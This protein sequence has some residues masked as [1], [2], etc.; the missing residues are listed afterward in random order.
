MHAGHNIGVVIP[1]R[2]EVKFINRVLTTLPTWVDRAVVVDDGS[3]DGTAEVARQVVGQAAIDIIRLEGE[4]VGSAINAGHQH[5]LS[6]W[7]EPF[8]SVVMAGDGQ[9]NPNDLEAVVDPVTRNVVDHSK[10]ERMSDGC[11]GMPV[12]RRVASHMLGFFT[13]LACGQR[14]LDPQCGYTATHSRV[15]RGMNW[16][17][18]W[19]GYGYPNHWLISMAKS[20]YRIGHVPV[21]SVYGDETSGIVKSAFFWKVGGMLILEHHRR[22]LSWLNPRRGTWSTYA[23]FAAYA[24]G[25]WS[26]LPVW[27]GSVEMVPLA[28]LAWGMAHLFDRQSVRTHTRR[29]THE[30]I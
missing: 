15:L 8:V 13:T 28:M 9:M 26:M 7:S 30:K 2:N 29:R 12:V 19:K 4:G 1:A 11:I 3:T 21:K 10:G 24:V 23:A 14:I 22:N 17:R 27:T 25:W 16:K 20:G 18:A 6:L 5:L